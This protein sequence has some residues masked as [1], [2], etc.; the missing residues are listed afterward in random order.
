MH[1]FAQAN[2]G[3]WDYDALMLRIYLRFARLHTTLAPYMLRTACLASTKA[4][5][6]MCPMALCVQGDEGTESGR[7]EVQYLLGGDLLVAPVV[8]N[9]DCVQVRCAGATASATEGA[10]AGSIVGAIA[11]ATAGA[12]TGATI[13]ATSGATT[14]ATVG[15]TAGA[16]AGATVGATA[17][18]TAGTTA[19]ATASA[20]VVVVAVPLEEAVAF[21]RE[22]AMMEVLPDDINTLEPCGAHILPRV[23]L[24]ICQLWPGG[25][26][27]TE[28]C[29]LLR[30]S[31]RYE[32][33]VTP[34][35][36]GLAGGT[37]RSGSSMG[38]GNVW[39]V[40]KVE[41]REMRRWRGVGGLHGEG[42]GDPPKLDAVQEDEGAGGSAAG[43]GKEEGDMRMRRAR[44]LLGMREGAV[45]G[46]EAGVLRLRSQQEQGGARGESGGRRVV[47]VAWGVMARREVHVMLMFECV[48]H[49]TL[50]LLP[51]I[52][53]AADGTQESRL[54]PWA[55]EARGGSTPLV[56]V[57]H[58][59]PLIRIAERRAIDHMSD[60]DH[61]RGSPVASGKHASPQAAAFYATPAPAHGTALAGRTAMR[62]QAVHSAWCAALWHLCC[63]TLHARHCML[64]RH[65][66]S[67]DASP[68]HLPPHHLPSPFSNPPFLLSPLPARLQVG[69]RSAIRC[70]RGG[71]A[72]MERGVGA[73]LS[74]MVRARETV[75]GRL[76]HI[77]LGLAAS[78]VPWNATDNSFLLSLVRQRGKWDVR[79]F[80]LMP[81][82][83]QLQQPDDFACMLLIQ[84]ACYVHMTGPSRLHAPSEGTPIAP[85]QPMAGMWYSDEGVRDFKRISTSNDL[86]SLY[87]DALADHVGR[88]VVRL[89][90]LEEGEGGVGGVDGRKGGAGGGRKGI[91]VGKERYG[92]RVERRE[93]EEE[94]DW[95][96][97]GRV[98]YSADE[99]GGGRRERDPHGQVAAPPI[100]V[101]TRTHQTSQLSQDRILNRNLSL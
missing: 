54:V 46:L 10:T 58:D 32:G 93:E 65:G 62:W 66:Q 22:G 11:G 64:P 84:D 100:R 41:G 19:G 57:A 94:G 53:G 99:G 5:S 13:G 67:H 3:P 16:T 18:A 23:A 25:A 37:A 31:H 26:G 39:K 70:R 81:G 8:N 4:R 44:R 96:D 1:Q 15:A 68:T 97:G 79:S 83:F 47:E 75:N 92:G 51:P 69:G 95:R 91:G 27:S 98:G 40:G 87:P 14:G 20:T 7:W 73:H 33:T 42:D 24:L 55:A 63:M 101:R 30:V 60:L 9:T 48:P 76:F 2:N 6:M 36:V 21:V 28:L 77:A 12:T 85:A 34:A 49:I 90:G 43:E 78:K 59:V 80:S 72:G 56:V 35:I 45:Q 74:F 71:G 88:D 17:S 89:R 82:V 50:T 52:G 38:E 29:V 86:C 61:P